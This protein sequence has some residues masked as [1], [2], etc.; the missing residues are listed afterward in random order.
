MV[1]SAYSTKPDPES[2]RELLDSSE[3][4][5]FSITEGRDRSGAV[6]V[7]SVLAEAFKRIDAQSGRG[8]LTGLPSGFYDLDDMLGGFNPGEMTIIAARPSMGR[9]PSC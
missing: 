6:H 4:R 2:V 1:Q 5:I 8:E 3:H 9:R 7:E